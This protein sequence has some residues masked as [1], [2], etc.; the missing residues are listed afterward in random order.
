MVIP[1]QPTIGSIRILNKDVSAMIGTIT[2]GSKVRVSG[3]TEYR[4]W[5]IVD[6]ES[7][8]ELTECDF[9]IFKELP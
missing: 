4:G 5:S 7:G 6:L 3:Y 9:D 1:T 8:Q 2:K